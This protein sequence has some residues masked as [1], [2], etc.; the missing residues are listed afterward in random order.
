MG[1]VS[2]PPAQVTY[3]SVASA[4]ATFNVQAN[5]ASGAALG[6]GIGSQAGGFQMNAL[7]GAALA[8]RFLN[9]PSSVTIG[10][11]VY[12]EVSDSGGGAF[13][14]GSIG[15]FQPLSVGDSNGPGN[16]TPNAGGFLIDIY[17][18]I[19]QFYNTASNPGYFIGV[20]STLGVINAQFSTTAADAVGIILDSTAGVL[21]NNWGYITRRG[22]GVAGITNFAGPIV[23]AAGQ[24]FAVRISY[25]PNSDAG[26]LSVKQLISPGVWKSL[27]SN[28]KLAGLGA[29]VGT[30]VGPYV[31]GKNFVNSGNQNGVIFH[32]CVGLVDQFDVGSAF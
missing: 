21:A 3:N 22:A 31:G 23:A 30:R 2:N 5:M 19:G 11:V 8:N 16:N 32:R 27:L 17:A 9:V 6:N 14:W 29:A 15:T 4:G 28:L 7:A 18:G 25:P 10:N 20:T 12:V 13:G 24:F 1:F 26:L